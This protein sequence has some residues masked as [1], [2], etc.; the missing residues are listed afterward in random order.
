[1][2]WR[3]GRL[4]FYLDQNHTGTVRREQV[5]VRDGEWPFD[6]KLHTPILNVAVGGWSGPPDSGWTTQ[7]TLIENV[8]ILQ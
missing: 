1:M 8:V 2:E 5:A 4:D 7:T 6:E 3:P